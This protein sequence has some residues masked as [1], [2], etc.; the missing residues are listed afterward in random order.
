MLVAGLVD[1]CLLWQISPGF[2]GPTPSFSHV[3]LMGDW[4]LC[5]FRAGRKI[6]SGSFNCRQYFLLL[7]YQ[8]TLLAFLASQERLLICL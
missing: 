6:D 2:T 4:K 1:L 8:Q 3:N 7:V 5:L